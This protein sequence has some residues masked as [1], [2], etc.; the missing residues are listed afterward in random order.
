MTNEYIYGYESGYEEASVIQKEAVEKEA[1]DL[2]D[3]LRAVAPVPTDTALGDL[4][5]DMPK[6]YEPSSISL[7]QTPW[8]KI[9]KEDRTSISN[10]EEQK[11]NNILENLPATTTAGA[12]VGAGLGYLAGGKGNKT[13]S[14]AIGAGTGALAGTAIPYL[15]DRLYKLKNEGAFNL[16]LPSQAMSPLG[17]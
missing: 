1:I 2:K 17:R 16:R 4:R 10:E 9:L 12:G 15:I 13:L 6:K 14:T 3:I 5:L 11:K 8:H 7:L